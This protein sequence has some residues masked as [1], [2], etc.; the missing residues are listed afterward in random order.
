MKKYRL[1]RR[2]NKETRLARNS[3]MQSKSKS[4][5]MKKRTRLL[6][7][8]EAKK[9]M[10]KAFLERDDN[11]RMMPGKNDAKRRETGVKVQKRILCD[12]LYNLFDE[13]EA[14]NPDERM[15]RATFCR[16]RPKHVVLA[17]FT[18]RNTCLCQHHQTWPSYYVL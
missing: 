8:H 14:E 12:Y 10:V 1:I 4:C 3:L 18:S 7:L 15:S 9:E 11:S 6:Q 2:M 13:F 16:L 17:S 5:V